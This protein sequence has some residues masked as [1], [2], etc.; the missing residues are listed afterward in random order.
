[1]ATSRTHTALATALCP[2]N[3]SRRKI[4]AIMRRPVQLIGITLSC[5]AIGVDQQTPGTG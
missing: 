2:N 5:P 1:M 4:L 3:S